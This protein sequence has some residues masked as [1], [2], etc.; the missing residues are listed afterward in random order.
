MKKIVILSSFDAS[1]HKLTG[2]EKEYVAESLEKFSKFAYSS[3]ISHGL[4]LKKLDDGLYEFRAGI[5]LRIVL[6]S[7]GDT[8][9]LIMAGDHDDVKAYL[10][11]YR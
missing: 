8:Y 6:E 9:Y 1:V 11:R 5:R 3:Q 4:G 10:R 2:R 7:S